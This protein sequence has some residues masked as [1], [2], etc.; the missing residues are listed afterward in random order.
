MKPLVYIETTI[1]SFFYDARQEPEMVARRN[2][3]REWWKSY[4]GLFRLRTS[5]AVLTE[6]A[7]GNYAS[8][9]KAIALMDGIERLGIPDRVADIVGFYLANHLMPRQRLGDALHLA[10]A[11]IHRC[12]FL[13]TWNCRHIANANKFVHLRILNHR[14]GLFVPELVTPMELCKE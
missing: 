12:D 9:E 5:E 1:P 14:L 11:S 2:W 4:R 3:T 13:L 10:V 7:E 8:Q 6:L